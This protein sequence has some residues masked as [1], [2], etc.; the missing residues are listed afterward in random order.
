MNIEIF[1]FLDLNVKVCICF[2]FSLIG[3]LYVG[4]VCMVFYFWL[5]VKY[6]NGEF[7]LCIEDIDLEC[8]IFEII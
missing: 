5:Y 4:G 7:V 8:L 3:Y 6:F 1:F 2:V